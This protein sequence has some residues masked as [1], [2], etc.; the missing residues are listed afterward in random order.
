M[1]SRKGSG[2]SP[3]ATQQSMLRNRKPISNPISP[4][5]TV[6]PP[7][8]WPVTLFQTLRFQ[9]S[10]SSP[11]QHEQAQLYRTHKYVPMCVPRAAGPDNQEWWSWTLRRPAWWSFSQSSAHSCSCTPPPPM[12]PSSLAFPQDPDSAAFRGTQRQLRDN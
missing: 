10:P 8:D 12:P 9:L 4:L 7:S 2:M 1:H 3:R 5:S 6:I 11:P